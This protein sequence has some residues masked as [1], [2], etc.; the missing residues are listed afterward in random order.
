[1]IEDM[2][3]RGL[4]PLTQRAYLHAIQQFALY[5]GKSPDQISDEEL[6]QYFLYL[7]NHKHVARSTATVALCALKFLSLIGLYYPK[8]VGNRIKAV[9]GNTAQ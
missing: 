5:Y 3:L 2:Q 7:H 9:G 8:I 1:M 4:A 6:R